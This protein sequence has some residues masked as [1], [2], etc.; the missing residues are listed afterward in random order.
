[1]KGEPVKAL[2]V[3]LYQPHAHY[4]LPFT[5]RRRHSYPIPP[6]STVRGFLCNV[7]NIRGHTLG[8]DPEANEDFQRLKAAKIG[9]AGRF[10]TKTTEYMWFRNLG[11]KQHISRFGS[12]EGRTMWGVGEHPGGQLPVWV[13]VL[14]E[15]RIV[16]YLVHEDYAFLE[17]LCEKIQN[18]SERFYPLYLGR[19]EDWVVVEDVNKDV[20]LEFKAKDADFEHFFWV[21]EKLFLP[22]G[23]SF[24][25]TQVEGI[26][27]RVPFFWELR[28]GSRD[29]RYVL[30]KLSDGRIK[31]I[32]FLFDSSFGRKGL[33]VFLLNPGV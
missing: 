24:D 21:P 13:D 28:E 19:S 7:L 33:P 6:Y 10:E 3:V 8:R 14:N 25:F 2:R 11:K 31:N 32:S 22:P 16:V 4:R 27:Y 15:V 18:P 26:F 20:S 23:G 17:R 29:F 30:A 12:T 1:V 9:I 5:Y